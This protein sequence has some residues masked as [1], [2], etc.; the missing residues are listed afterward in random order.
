MKKPRK[1]VEPVRV[2]LGMPEAKD[3]LNPDDPATYQGLDP[4]GEEMRFEQLRQQER[5]V[6]G[7]QDGRDS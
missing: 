2:G 5:R 4:V 7:G 3:R 6:T 1:N